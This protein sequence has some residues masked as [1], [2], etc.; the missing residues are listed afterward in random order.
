MDK[1]TIRNSQDIRNYPK[2]L[3]SIDPTKRPLRRIIIHYNLAYMYPCGLKGCHQPHLDGYLVELEDGYVT[4]VGWKCGKEFGDKFVAEERRYR[5]QILRPKVIS[6]IQ[7][8]LPSIKNAQAEMEQLEENV[9]RISRCKHAMRSKVPR[10]YKDLERRAHASNDRV[11]EQIERT[12]K[13]IEDMQAMNPGG[14]RDRFRYR[15]EF[16]GQIPG[17]NVLAVSVREAVV[18][19]LTAKA[20]TLLSSS[21]STLTT[22]KLVEWEIWLNH[23]DERVDNARKLVADGNS[24]FTKDCFRLLSHI[25]TVQTEKAALPKLT[26]AVL[27]NAVTS[28][29][30]QIVVPAE[31]AALSKKQRDINKR[32]EAMLRKPK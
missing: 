24:F 15:E 32:M 28:Q 9:D 25:A 11:N 10:L 14:S 30:K 4:N 26:T 1:L 5:D 3:D 2:Y 18:T 12:H 21:I 8:I 31:P 22:D 6:Q 17:L 13:E 19:N 29:M 7:S 20:R 16:L 23:F 27:L